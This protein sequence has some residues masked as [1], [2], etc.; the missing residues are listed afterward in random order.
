MAETSGYVGMNVSDVETQVTSLE[1]VAGNMDELVTSVS[2]LQGPLEENWQG[3]EATAATDYLNN[4]ATKMADMSENLRAI[5]SWVKTT[6]EGYEEAA[7][8]GAKAYGGEG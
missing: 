3:I 1:T 2:G 7:S 6:K 5:S 8:E 4:L